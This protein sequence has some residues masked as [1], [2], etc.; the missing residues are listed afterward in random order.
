MANLTLNREMQAMAERL[1][2]NAHDI[3]AKGFREQSA[4]MGGVIHPQMVPYDLLTDREK[5][6]SRER[7]QELL[8][9]LQ[10]EGFKVLKFVDILLFINNLCLQLISVGTGEIA[11]ETTRCTWIHL[12]DL[13]HKATNVDLLRPC[14]RSCCST[15]TPLRS[16]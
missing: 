9:F 6:K 12:P 3:W 5:K 1:A 8:K 11:I 15:W 14:W 16:V 10:Y 7:S 4:A 13:L 2:E